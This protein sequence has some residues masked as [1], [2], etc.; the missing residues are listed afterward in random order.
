[1]TAFDLPEDE[2]LELFQRGV[3]TVE[4]R[5]PYSS[6]ATLLV[7]IRATDTDGSVREARAVYKPGNGE[8][9]L[10]DFPS[11]LYRREEAMYRLSRALKLE[12]IP[13]T[14]IGL[15]PFGEGSYQAF[16]DADFSQHYFSLHE[17]GVGISDM[18]ALCLL[19]II[20]NNTD[21]KSGHC[22]I[23]RDG[24]VYGIDNGLSFH[25]Q[26][27]LRTV[28]WDFAGQPIPAHLL[29]ALEEFLDRG[30]PPELTELLDP[31]EIDA[32]LTRARAVLAEGVFPE[33]DTDGHRWPW[34][35]I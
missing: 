8:R 31:I 20:A 10:W 21:R 22:L 26:F 4:G 32:M 24:H 1:M 16:V 17:A 25:A 15:G 9:P 5:M 23:G 33:D 19:D 11:G 14:V 27:K 28:I 30:P 3:V 7:T 29:E 35:L 34:P 12:V 6:N 13:P 18:Q 2:L